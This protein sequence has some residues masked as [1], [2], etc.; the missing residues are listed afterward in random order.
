MS[1][2]VKGLIAALSANIIWGFVSIAFRFLKDY[3][4]DIILSYRIVIAFFISWFFIISF[5]R[6]SLLS[7]LE[8]VS[9]NKD[10]PK[11]KFW[12]LLIFS[13]IFITLNWFAFIYVINNVNLKSAA[14]AYMICPLI[15]AVGG[16]IVLKEELTKQKFVALIIAAV[17]IV[18]LATGSLSDV[19]WSA[20]IALFYA[21]FV[22]LQRIIKNFDRLNMLGFQLLV[23]LLFVIPL[24]VFH[25]HTIPLNLN[26]WIAIFIVGIIFTLIPLL[27][28]LYAL[29]NLPSSTVG[30]LIYINPIVAFC[31]AFFYFHESIKLS[32]I[33]S[34]ILLAFA[35]LIFNWKI[36]SD[37][38]FKNFKKK[39]VD[40]IS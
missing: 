32:Q 31:I 8:E 37:N 15:T 30:I 11:I 22:I 39:N 34:Y 24:F 21:S 23:G 35:V 12:M 10:M 27:L 36:L 4:A 40:I 13:G 29:G 1:G 6:K 16:F 3:P 17:S 18:I 25:P 33:F 20:L 9:S 38:L 2:K 28:S 14:F 5:K 26:F 19:L 7:D